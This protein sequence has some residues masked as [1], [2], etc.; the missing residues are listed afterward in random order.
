MYLNINKNMIWLSE[1][2]KLIHCSTSHYFN[3]LLLNLRVVEK[4]LTYVNSVTATYS[5]F[6]YSFKYKNI[7][8]VTC[9]K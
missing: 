2:H 9:I 7:Y 8:F 1:L 6:S 4:Y 3:G 5:R